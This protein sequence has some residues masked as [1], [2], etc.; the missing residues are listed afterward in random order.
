MTGSD[1]T[2]HDATPADHTPPDQDD[3]DKAATEAAIGQLTAVRGSAEKWAGT[4]TALLG[5]FTTVA[6]VTRVD[7]LADVPEG[8]RLLAFLLV[9]AAGL[10]AALSIVLAA[11]AAQGFGLTRYNVWNGTALRAMLTDQTPKAARLLAGSR[12]TGLL[13]AL[14]LFVLGV[15]TLY[16]SLDS[17]E[18]GAGA[19]VVVVTEDGQLRCGELDGAD[20]GSVTVAGNPVENVAQVLAVDGC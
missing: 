2:G 5:I 17:P 14:A 11:A 9:V 7:A 15:L 8:W 3:W 12:W 6:L 4:L 13:A 16:L 19:S 1:V 20:D 10:A 18:E